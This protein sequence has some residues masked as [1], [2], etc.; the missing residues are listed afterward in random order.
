MRTLIRILILV[1]AMILLIISLFKEYNSVSINKPYSNLNWEIKDDI[2]TISGRGKMQDYQN[3]ATPW[4]KD[5]NKI[6]SIVIKPGI[7]Y[8]GNRAFQFCENARDASI[9]D[10]VQTIGEAVFLNCKKLEHIRMPERLSDP[11][12][13]VYLF[14]HCASL[15]SASIPNGVKTIGKGAF[16]S[17]ESL[18]WVYIPASVEKIGPYAFNYCVSLEDVYYGGSAEAWNAVEI[19]AFNDSLREAVVH[20]DSDVK[21]LP[22]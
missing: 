7:T 4:S 21:L 3:I 13:P 1:L 12:L 8:I 16:N 11:V 18:D 15:R 19:Q 9:P 2:L 17:C 5:Q 14:D 10:S 20:F 6:K 22:N